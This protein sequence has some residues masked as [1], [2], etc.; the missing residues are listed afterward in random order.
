MVSKI[1]IT[2]DGDVCYPDENNNAQPIGIRI[3]VFQFNNP[4]GLEKL[5]DS[6]YEVT[7][8]SG[9]PINEANSN[10]VERSDVIQGYLEG[11]NVRIEF[12]GHH[13]IWRDDA[14]G[15]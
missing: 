15:K 1:T 3:G 13:R 2:K 14:A 4:N 9:Q 6:L 10:A 7:A 8:A 12:Q 11:S 5:G